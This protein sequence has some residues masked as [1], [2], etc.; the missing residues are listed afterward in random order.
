MAKILIYISIITAMVG[1]ASIIAFDLGIIQLSLFR[2]VI[3]LSFFLTIVKKK[4]IRLNRQDNSLYSKKFMFIWVIYALF[5]LA[6]VQD[7]NMWAK[8]M[9]FLFI[10]LIVFITLPSYLKKSTDILK[11]FKYISIMVLLHN[12]FGWYEILTSNYLFLATEKIPAYSRGSFPVSTFGNSNDY[13]TFLLF[14]IWVL[15]ICIIN[16]KTKILKVIYILLL[17]SSLFLL[18]STKSRAN[19]LALVLS[20][21]VFVIMSLR[22]S[23]T[24]T[25]LLIILGL[26]LVV[27]FVNPNIFRSVIISINENLKFNFFT[28]GGSDN[29]RLNL[30]KNGLLYLYSTLGFGV[31]AGNIEY[32]MIHEALYNT[33]GISNIHNWW[34]EILIG[35]GIIIFIMYIVFYYK[36]FKSALLKFKYS[37]C[38]I[39]MSI[40]MGIMCF[41]IGYIIGSI[42]SSSN[43]NSEWLWVFWGIAVAYQGIDDNKHN[44]IDNKKSK[45]L[46]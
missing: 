29:I 7:Y 9:F 23:K 14:S 40:S 8:S 28:Q 16:T 38:K 42:S 13:A 31:G 27:L 44:I 1:S 33:G 15:Y 10:G 43:I 5:S 46:F 45:I 35:Y 25:T 30:I 2:M 20:I 18:L 26:I 21:I 36:L 17:V 39:D 19:L 3:L 41:M 34:F 12:V 24:R 37:R 6:W 4:K 22:K 32:W 11:A